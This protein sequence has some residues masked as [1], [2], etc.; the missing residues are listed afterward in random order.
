MFHSF[1]AILQ[2]DKHICFAFASVGSLQESTS[3]HDYPSNLIFSST[4]AAPSWN[5]LRYFTDFSLSDSWETTS[6]WGSGAGKIPELN[7][8]LKCHA[9]LYVQLYS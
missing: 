1:A 4:L 8:L 7:H 9:D 2:S 3:W 6:G 5:A